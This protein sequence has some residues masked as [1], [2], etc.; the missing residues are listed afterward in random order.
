MTDTAAQKGLAIEAPAGE[1]N[2]SRLERVISGPGTVEALG[3]ELDRR[4][5]K[6]AIVVTGATLGKSALLG[7]VTGALGARC[8]GVFARVRQHVP[9]GAVRELLAEVARLNADCLVSFGGGSPIDCS[10]VAAYAVLTGRDPLAAALD[11]GSAATAEETARAREIV[12]IAVPTTIS[13]GEYTHVAGVTDEST[14]I[15]SGVGD[16]RILAKTVINDP[17]L[18]LETPDW[19][20]VSTGMR[21]FDHA[22]ETIYSTRHQLM[23]DTLGSKAIELLDAHLPASIRT[24]GDER[25]AHRG[26][27]QLASWFSIFGALNTGFGL[28][29]ALGH[30]IGPK[31]DVPHGVTS[32]ITLPHVMRFMA[33]M[34]PERF[35]PIARGFGIAFDLANP[36]PGAL[37]CADRTEKFIAQ[38]DVP[39]RLRD[40]HVP[41]DEVGDIAGTIAHHFARLNVVDRPVTREEILDL[42]QAAY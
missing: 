2:L 19:L 11:P 20:W 8:V 31:W 35:G 6:R 24:T 9:I 7:K 22:V 16:P 12:H 39:K 33:Q 38:F 21:S 36:K 30:Q 1:F 29:H 37:A 17:L 32:C 4:N 27:C 25:V 23:S 42:L 3:N 18:T 15:K 13:A 5:L 14:R 10:K 41:K 34:A 40:A 28:S 26:F